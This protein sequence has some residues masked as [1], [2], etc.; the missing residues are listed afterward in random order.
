MK[1]VKAQ[2]AL[3]HEHLRRVGPEEPAADLMGWLLKDVSRT[4]AADA[5]LD[6]LRSSHYR[7]LRAV[8]RAGIRMTELGDRIGM[9]TQGSG[10]FVKALVETGHLRVEVHD[11]DRRSRVVVRTPAGDRAVAAIGKR[12]KRIEGGWAKRV[13][14]TRYDAF[15]S[16][17]TELTND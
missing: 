17:L 5:S 15:R 10:Q 8:P 16:V 13:G 6:G 1:S 2:P 3:S 11:A 4:L 12:I 7:L 9:T 14:A